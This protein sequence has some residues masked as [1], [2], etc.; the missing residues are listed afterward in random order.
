MKDWARTWSQSGY[1]SGFPF[2]VQ[3]GTTHHHAQLAAR[4]VPKIAPTISNTGMAKTTGNK[5]LAN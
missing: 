2:A 5:K 3:Q 4:L 1:L